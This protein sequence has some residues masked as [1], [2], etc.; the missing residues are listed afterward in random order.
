MDAFVQTY[1][2]GGLEKDSVDKLYAKFEKIDTCGLFFPV[3]ITEM[4]FLGE[5]IFGKGVNR[6]KIY[7]EVD[8]LVSFL[9][10]LANRK[11]GEF[12]N[13][14]HGGEYSKFAI[15]IVGKQYK[16]EEEGKQIYINNIR[17]ITQP[18]ETLYLIGNPYN[19]KI[20]DEI[21]FDLI[22]DDVWKIF[23]KVASKAKLRTSGG[24]EF[25]VKNYIIS[26]RKNLLRLSHGDS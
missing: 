2:R 6:N 23:H 25:D 19:K 15:R 21:S 5:K 17:Q 10:T 16:I 22:E 12:S 11:T 1:L 20:I 4:T 8:D 13:L 3:F 26:L 24:E 18:I 7:K 14:E 9:L